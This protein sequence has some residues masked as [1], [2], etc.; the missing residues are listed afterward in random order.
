[1]IRDLFTKNVVLFIGLIIAIILIGIFGFVSIEKWS[2]WDAFFMTIITITTVGYGE[3]HPLSESGQI[4]ASILIIISFGSFAFAYTTVSSYLFTGQ[5]QKK[6]RT[7]RKE[8][9]V[10]KMKGH[11]VVCGYGRVGQQVVQDMINHNLSVVVIDLSD[12]DTAIV[13]DE[14]FFFFRGDATND[15]MLEKANVQYAAVLISCLPK[16][17]DNIYVVLAAK[18]LNDQIKIVSRASDESAIKKLKTAGAH[19]V[20]MPDSIGGAHMASIITNPDVV[21]FIDAIRIQGK[22]G[23]N[24]ES[25][26]CDSLPQ[27][28]LNKPISDLEIKK[29]TGATIIGIKTSTG[30]FII[31][32]DHHQLMIATNTLIVLG[33]QNQI[34]ELNKYLGI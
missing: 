20:I 9:N 16:D 24:M 6:L 3:V 11:V 4:F 14:H 19:H 1:M 17:V 32:P 22:Q 25:I 29:Q 12:N 26:R 33:T 23:V 34:A 8:R 13:K 7:L 15:L 28:L 30:E 2:L 10:K 21:E 27:E 5:Y 31:N 18:E